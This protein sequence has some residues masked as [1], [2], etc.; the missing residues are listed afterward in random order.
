M[1]EMPL[2]AKL[3]DMEKGP[4]RRRNTL[5]FR[6]AWKA[7]SHLT[8][9]DRKNYLDNLFLAAYH[10]ERYGLQD[11]CYVECG[12]W[13]GGMS[14]GMMKVLPRI[15]SWYFFDSY[16]GLPPAQDLDGERAVDD[17]RSG[18]LRFDNNTASYDDFA[19]NAER[20]RAPD[21]RVEIHPGWFE[22]TLVGFTPDS[23]ISVLRLDGDWYESTRVAL[24]A[25]YD[26][27]RDH[28]VVIIDDYYHWMGCSR[29]VHDFLSE[30]K[31]PD[32]IRD[33]HGVAYITKG[34]D[35]A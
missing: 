14:F 3:P 31:S 2:S 28:G 11:G 24:D 27:V 9:V 21:Q 30:R 6:A 18:R 23:P 29:A 22:K 7:F 4:F 10:V 17:Q 5:R 35:P 33:R 1:V 25:L 26:H 8:M 34:R 12:T 19:A 15:R 20:Y 16:E 32:R 13:R